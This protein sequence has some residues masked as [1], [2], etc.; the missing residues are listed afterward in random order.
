MYDEDETR[1]KTIKRRKKDDGERRAAM[2][3]KN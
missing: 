2:P 3:Y 1:A